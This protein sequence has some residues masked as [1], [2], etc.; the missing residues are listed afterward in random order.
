M[1]NSL[2]KKFNVDVSDGKGTDEYLFEAFNEYDAACRYLIDC[3]PNFEFDSIPN[4][5]KEII[6]L[7]KKNGIKLIIEEVTEEAIEGDKKNK[8]VETLIQVLKSKKKFKAFSSRENK[9][10]NLSVQN[11]ILGEFVS[12]DIDFSIDTCMNSIKETIPYSV[13]IGKLLNGK[14][15]YAIFNNKDKLIHKNLTG[16]IS[17]QAKMNSIEN[18]VNPIIEDAFLWIENKYDTGVNMVFNRLT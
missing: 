7:C 6:S 8:D 2:I 1:K 17:S 3:N 5:L 14:D 16:R 18:E 15:G 11:P 10:V 9:M 12:I 13:I 4:S